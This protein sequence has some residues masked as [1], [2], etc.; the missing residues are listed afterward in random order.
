MKS[1]AKAADKLQPQ[2]SNGGG[3]GNRG[4]AAGTSLQQ[5]RLPL[6]YRHH[7]SQLQFLNLGIFHFKSELEPS[8]RLVLLLRLLLTFVYSLVVCEMGALRA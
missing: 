3:R 2:P 1:S 8:S 6:S 5:A 7:R 4:A